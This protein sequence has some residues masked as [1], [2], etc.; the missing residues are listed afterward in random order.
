MPGSP[1][2]RRR[3]TEQRGGAMAE[4]QQLRVQEAVDSMVKSL[5]RENIRKMQVAGRGLTRGE[6]RR[7]GIPGPFQ[8]PP[9]DPQRHCLPPRRPGSGCPWG[10]RGV[11]GS[12]A[13][14][15]TELLELRL[16]G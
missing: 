5:E 9:H 12:S 3:G 7:S 14:P 13:H 6:P 10:R 4:L 1:C 11:L 15:Q 16:S 2:G 8:Q